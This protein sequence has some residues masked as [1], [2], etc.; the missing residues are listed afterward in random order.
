MSKM[1]TGDRTRHGVSLSHLGSWE[2]AELEKL[3]N[4]G[5]YSNEDKPSGGAAGR[6]PK[7]MDMIYITRGEAIPGK[8]GPQWKLQCNAY[9]GGLYKSFYDKDYSSTQEALEVCKKLRD[10][11]IYKMDALNSPDRVKKFDLPSGIYYAGTVHRYLYTWTDNKRRSKS[12]SIKSHGWE[13]AL[14]KAIEFKERME[15]G[16]IKKG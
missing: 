10:E 9:G 1:L 12:F 13:K 7:S 3:K 8:Q 15:N 5:K 14:R 4:A 2:R 16:N 6:A 11:H